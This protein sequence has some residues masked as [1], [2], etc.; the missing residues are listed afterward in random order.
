MAAGQHS[1]TERVIEGWDDILRVLKDAV[2]S[3]GVSA[4]L[5]LAGGNILVVMDSTRVCALFFGT[6][7]RRRAW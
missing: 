7:P 5:R 6:F 4:G 1:D 3:V 2:S